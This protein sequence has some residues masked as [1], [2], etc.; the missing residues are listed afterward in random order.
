[1]GALNLSPYLAIFGPSDVMINPFA[2][3]V[4]GGFNP[5]SLSPYML[6][7]ATTL[8][9]ADGSDVTI[10]PDVGGAGHDAAG[11]AGTGYGSA[12]RPQL[13]KSIVNGNDVVR[14]GA[15]TNCA[16]TLGN[17]SAFTG[18]H[19]FAVLKTPAAPPAGTGDGQVMEAGNSGSTSYFTFLDG[20]IYDDFGSTVRKGGFAPNSTPAAW[21][22]YEVESAAGN[23]TARQDS[24]QLFNTGTNT[25]SFPTT[26]YLGTAG[27]NSFPLVDI[28]YFILF[29]APLSAPNATLVR[30][31]LKTR[32]GT[33]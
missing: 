22:I 32:F 21:G 30:N 12:V 5:V 27:S 15:T 2:F 11:M 31:Y 25:V 26:A 13:K 4:A 1:M 29:N 24:V 17:L 6:L 20:N 33:P 18:G 9:G 19:F 28:A 7:D 23:W 16:F 8:V 14:W 10:W 3:A